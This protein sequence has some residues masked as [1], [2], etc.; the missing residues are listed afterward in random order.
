MLKFLLALSMGVFCVSPLQAAEIT[1]ADIRAFQAAMAEAKGPVVD[2]C[3]S[4]TRALTLYA[5]GEVL[6]GRMKLGDIEAFGQNLGF[7]LA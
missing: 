3:K 7:D 1:E 6:D 2:H 4:G 5:L